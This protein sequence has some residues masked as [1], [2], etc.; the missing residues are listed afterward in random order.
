MS[1]QRS[2]KPSSR[3]KMAEFCTLHE[4]P[5]LSVADWAF[6]SKKVLLKTPHT[7]SVTINKSTACDGDSLSMRSKILGPLTYR[8][9]WRTTV[10]HTSR[11]ITTSR[12]GV[13]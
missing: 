4:L 8:N 11:M 12:A 9:A 6:A 7:R 3:E 13:L 1:W 2:K 5:G 10:L